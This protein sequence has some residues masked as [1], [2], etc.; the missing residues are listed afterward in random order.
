MQEMAADVARHSAPWKPSQNPW[1]VGIEGIVALVIG[2]YVV[3]FP[4]DANDVIRVLIAVALLLASAGR[5][6][7]GFRFWN[8]RW[9]PW[10]TLG[11]GAGAM[12]AA[13]TLLSTY[14]LYIQPP[15]ARQMLAVG[16]LTFGIIELLALIFTVRSTGFTIAAFIIDLLAIALGI[17]LLRAEANDTSGTQ[18]LGVTAIIGGVALLLYAYI[19]WSTP[20]RAARQLPVDAGNAISPP[21]VQSDEL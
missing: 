1:V 13:L 20:R 17:L 18:L 16:L 2:I 11:G 10:A 19:L 9:S 14:S 3:A 8:R 4:I 15:G 12:A 6:V 7:E 5:I 21:A